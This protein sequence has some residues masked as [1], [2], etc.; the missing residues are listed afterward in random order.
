MS[1][2]GSSPRRRP[3]AAMLVACLALFVALSGG[4]YAAILIPNN[5]VGTAQLRNNSVS[6][7]KLAD[8]AVGTRKINNNAITYQK[9]APGQI[10]HARVAQSQIQWRVTGTCAGRF[11]AIN[12]VLPT[13]GVTCV[14][15]LPTDYSTAGLSDPLTSTSSATVLAD[16]TLPANSAYQL[17][18]NPYFQV[19][20]TGGDQTVTI[21]CEIVSGTASQVRSIT[22]N[23]DPAHEEAATTLALNLAVPTSGSSTRAAVGCVRSFTGTVA[24][25]VQA[26]ASLDA[27]QVAQDVTSVTP[28]TSTT[29]FTLTAPTPT[30]TTKTTP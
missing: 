11:A 4:A 5:S 18:S 24:P 9:I 29:A 10:G 27:L 3:S 20:G 13:G 15:T 8:K 1:N 6:F 14:N 17:A 2:S 7:A 16:E 22:V 26:S 21:S 19:R 12:H 23:L 28:G 30:V 25:V